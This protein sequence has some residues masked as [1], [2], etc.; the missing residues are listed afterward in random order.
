M[1][2][3]IRSCA[4]CGSIV[5]LPAGR[6][7]SNLPTVERGEVRRVTLLPAVPHVPRG[8]ANGPRQSWRGPVT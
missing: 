2:P 6:L 5:G 1:M 3:T 7:R 8:R 4:R